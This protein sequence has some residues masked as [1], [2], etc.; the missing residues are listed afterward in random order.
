MKRLYQIYWPLELVRM[1]FRLRMSISV[2]HVR[3]AGYIAGTLELTQ[4]RAECDAF[5]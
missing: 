1:I 4:G 5:R 2:V 3:P